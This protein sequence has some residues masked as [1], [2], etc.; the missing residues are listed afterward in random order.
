MS[1]IATIACRV[2]SRFMRLVIFRASGREQ[3]IANGRSA[4]SCRPR[5]AKTG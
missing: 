1:H 4:H 5:L 2:D 3:T